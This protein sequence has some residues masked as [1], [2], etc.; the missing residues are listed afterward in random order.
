MH[1][2]TAGILA[3]AMVPARAYAGTGWF[4]RRMSQILRR[5][6]DE[7]DPA[8]SV[9][10]QDRQH[11]LAQQAREVAVKSTTPLQRWESSLD[12]PVSL[13]VLPLFAFL[14]AGVVLFG[15]SVSLV[16]APVAI[17]VALGL[18]VGKVAGISGFAWLGIKSG[19]CSLPDGVRFIHIVAL[20]LLAGIGF[21]MSLFI[22]ALAFADQP[23]LLM[24]A[25]LGILSGSLFAGIAGVTLFLLYPPQAASGQK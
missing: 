1:A 10:E 5:Y 12:R 3:A 22:S 24:D 21:T 14:N 9:L 7:D 23:Q 17:A 16:S 20:G 13:A 4:Q 18:C 15:D 6:A 2:T 8:Q 25:K 11:E 19:L